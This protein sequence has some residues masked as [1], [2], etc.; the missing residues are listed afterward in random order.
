MY[1]PRTLVLRT[2]VIARC[3]IMYVRVGF[4]FFTVCDN[5]YCMLYAYAYDI[6]N[7]H[8]YKYT[9]S[10]IRIRKQWQCR[11]RY[12]E[13]LTL[14]QLNQSVTTVVYTSDPA[15]KVCRP[16]ATALH[17]A[18]WRHVIPRTSHQLPR[19][20]DLAAVLLD[21]EPEALLFRGRFC[22]HQGVAPVVV[23]RAFAVEVRSPV[24]ATLG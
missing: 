12:V 7:T 5:Q 16:V 8:G 20:D 10:R 9:K 11:T 23:A 15:V 22:R 2:A 18:A 6:H 24:A 17:A 3:N 19:R 4:Y 1:L 21:G 14:W 13:R